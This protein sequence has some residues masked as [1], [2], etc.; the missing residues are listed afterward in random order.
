MK[1]NAKMKQ[2]LKILLVEDDDAFREQVVKLLGVYNDIFEA[3]SLA[4]GRDKLA[5]NSFDVVL[6]DKNLPDGN[7]LDLIDDIR[8][9]N[10]HTVVIVLTGDSNFN[11]V[12]KCIDA[13]AS[14]YL[15]KSENI[16]PDLLVRIPMAISRSALERQS[17]NLSSRLKEAFRFEVVGR[18][19]AMAELRTTVQSLKDSQSP[20]LITGESGTGKELIARRLHA[21][22]D[23]AS[24][25][26]VA[27]NCGAIPE[28]LVESELF[29]HVKGSFSGA[30]ED[31]IGK[32]ELA[33]GGDIFLDEVGELSIQ[34]QIKLLRVLQEGEIT[35]VGAKKTKK[36][37]VRIIAAT[38]QPL[39]DLVAQKKFR[40]DLYYRLNVFR[41]PTVPLRDRLEDIPDLAQ[42]F[43]TQLGGSRFSFASDALKYL[44]RQTW[45]GNIRELRNIIERAVL[46]AKRR[47]ST[48]LEKSDLATRSTSS[49]QSAR[50]TFALP[51]SP[52]DLT[53][54][55]YREFLKN[56]EREYL[57]YALEL[58]N[59][60]LPETALKLGIGKTTLFEKLGKLG[61]AT[62]KRAKESTSMP[63]LTTR[64]SDSSSE[65]FH[66]A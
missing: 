33:D 42:F 38:N 39:E 28:N 27:I 1:P 62:G 9:N 15:C 25:P 23:Q 46:L 7:G 20:V 66:E 13:G 63:G 59:H 24:R 35:P 48:V 44:S 50:P 4:Q 37:S 64:E 16:V 56:T 61:L 12:Q 47:A 55:R 36:V 57:R 49:T 11:L 19:A 34:T 41:I 51:Q 65:V 5:N 18:S 10:K 8:L 53:A 30:H 3:A 21:V 31:Q 60:S 26:F 54:D 6:L 32:F 14:D 2:D 17:E 52:Q 45:P 22:E 43:L 40:E 58:C 29:G